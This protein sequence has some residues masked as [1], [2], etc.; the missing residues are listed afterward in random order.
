MQV[1]NCSFNYKYYKYYRQNIANKKIFSFAF[2]SGR[3]N[4]YVYYEIFVYEE[5]YIMR[6]LFI[7]VSVILSYVILET[8]FIVAKDAYM[9]KFIDESS[10]EGCEG[11][12]KVNILSITILQH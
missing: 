7:L 12:H 10:V 1:A 3:F 2:Q 11:N 6:S 8:V 5:M 9:Q 4:S